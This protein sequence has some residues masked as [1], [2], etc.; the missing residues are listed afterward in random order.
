MNIS[1]ILRNNNILAEICTE[2]INRL[3]YYSI[4][5]ACILFYKFSRCKNIILTGIKGKLLP[6]H[7]YIEGIKLFIPKNIP[8]KSKLG[9]SLDSEVYIELKES[10]RYIGRFLISKNEYFDI[11]AQDETSELN[12]DYSL[13]KLPKWLAFDK[14]ILH[15]DKC[16]NCRKF[17]K[18]EFDKRVGFNRGYDDGYYDRDYKP[19]NEYYIKGYEEGRLT[20]E[21]HQKTGI[22]KKENL[23]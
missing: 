20:K 12:D 2:A 5:Q 18:E 15:E 21:R 22:Y 8:E 4:I 16:K 19:Y 9:L 11:W 14:E 10:A 7:C 13:N 23:L 1:N 6:H 3:S 17:E